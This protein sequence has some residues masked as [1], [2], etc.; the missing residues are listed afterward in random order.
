MKISLFRA[1]LPLDGEPG[2]PLFGKHAFFAS[3]EELQGT[4]G[5]SRDGTPATL[6][7][8]RPRGPGYR[9]SPPRLS[10]PRRPNSPPI[11]TCSFT[12]N[13]SHPADS[14]NTIITFLVELLIVT[15][16]ITP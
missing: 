1:L 11:A 7:A 12:N 3:R 14:E 10:P 2:E 15:S 4:P 6:A 8:P 13:V 16:P 9:L 5:A